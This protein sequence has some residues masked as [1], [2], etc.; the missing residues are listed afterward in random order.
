MRMNVCDNISKENAMTNQRIAL[1]R[2]GCVKR[3]GAL[4]VAGMAPAVVRGQGA[5][6]QLGVLTPLTGAG[7]FDGP[8][9]LKAMQG[10]IDEVNAAGGLLGRKVELVVEDDQTNPESAVRAAR[11]LIDV[12][13]VPAIMGTWASAVTTAV[14]PLC[15]ESRTFLTTVSGADS[16]TKLPHQGYLIRT[17]PNNYLQAAKHAE[18]I[19]A[20]GVKRCFMMSIQAPFSQ[21]TQERATERSEEHTSELQS[22][23]NL[24]CR[25]LLEKKNGPKGTAAATC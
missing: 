10:V 19:A 17:Q 15:W 1:S 23:T 13:K 25:L 22:Q 5:P 11:K 21:P 8:R 2:R 4:A 18:F 3:S 16:I 7:G 14:A 6:M 9:M 24:V 12:T 20:L